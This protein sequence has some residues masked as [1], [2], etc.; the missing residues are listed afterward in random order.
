MKFALIEM[1]THLKNVG[2]NK[3]GELKEN[4]LMTDIFATMSLPV[5]RLRVNDY[6][7]TTLANKTKDIPPLP[8]V[9]AKI[10]YPS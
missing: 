6:N 3:G 9:F 8:Q 10:I 4:K 1:L 5:D 7:T 2:E